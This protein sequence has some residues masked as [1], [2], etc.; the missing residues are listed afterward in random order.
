MSKDPSKEKHKLRLL[1]K[2]R[3]K[4]ISLN[5]YEGYEDS[6]IKN[7]KKAVGTFKN[8]IIAGYNPINHE[9]NCLNLLNLEFHQ[10]QKLRL[11]HHYLHFVIHLL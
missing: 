8:K 10:H 6:F 1:W 2:E 7:F 9:V 4:K 3:R 11:G 5:S